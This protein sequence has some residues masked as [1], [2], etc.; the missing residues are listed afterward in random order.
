MSPT[1]RLCMSLLHHHLSHTPHPSYSK[2][3]YR[4]RGEGSSSSAVVWT[5]PGCIDLPTA[6]GPRLASTV[7]KRRT[8]KQQNPQQGECQ[9]ERGLDASLCRTWRM[10]AHT[11]HPTHSRSATVEGSERKMREVDSQVILLQGRG[12]SEGRLPGCRRGVPCR[13]IGAQVDSYTRRSGMR[14]ATKAVGVSVRGARGGS[15]ELRN[16]SQG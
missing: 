14:V 12:P 16:F 9:V 2:L 4:H 8:L 3:L 15:R 6:H 11:Q 1:R 13:R 10:C 7:V 5:D